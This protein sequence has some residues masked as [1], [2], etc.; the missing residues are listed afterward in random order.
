[1][2]ALLPVF[3]LASVALADVRL[4][5]YTRQ[6]LPNGIVL[7]VMPRRDVPLV[8]IRVTIKGGLESDPESTGGLARITAEALRRG[9]S[10]RTAE[11]FSHE[12]DSLGATFNARVTEQSTEISTEF[13]ARD[14]DKGLDL[15]LDAVLSPSFPE[16]ELK[17]L[18]A[19]RIDEVRA[20]KDNPDAAA[21]SYYR[22]FFFG[23]THPYG[24][25]VDELTL[26]RITRD[27]VAGYHKRM[28]AGR[29]MIVVAA[30][31]VDAANAT[32]A[33]AKAVAGV[34][35][36]QMYLWKKAELPTRAE[37]QV[38]I[39]DKADATQTQILIGMPGIDRRDPNRIAL[40]LVNTLFGG[41]F[42]SIL[43]DELRVNTGL[44]YGARSQFDRNHLP[45]RITI[46]TFT[47]TENTG[48][49]L[50]VGLALLR[51]LAENGITT[52]QLSSAKAYLKGTYPAQALETPDQLAGVL[53]DIELFDLNRAEVDDLFSR[54]DAV[55]VE[56]A[57][58]MA[59]RYYGASA[60]A[61]LLLGNASKFA[62]QVSGYDADPVHVSITT[63]GLRVTQ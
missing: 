62:P 2:R 11:Q 41:R 18:L 16:S 38:A 13:L 26:S 58:E 60:L 19:Q 25:P 21:N 42:T 32:A 49:A 56:K 20:L 43:N 53:S 8:T 50:D 48:K 15:L 44:T 55:T 17:K 34:P 1:M 46:A 14:F 47:A 37:T 9:T 45:G 36:G 27:A 28:Y 61:I 6:V 3:C 5:Q 22:N 10:R 31:D 59:R 51:K 7:D 35:A 12:L 29:N 63:P 33:I 23:G 54:I 57:N 40:W 39:V 24:K 30:G 52:E 4:P